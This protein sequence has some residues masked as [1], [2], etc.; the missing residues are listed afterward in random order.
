MDLSY[1][2]AASIVLKCYAAYQMLMKEGPKVLEW[3][4][5]ITRR[6]FYDIDEIITE[7][8][9]GSI[10][11]G[12]QI[13]CSG[14]LTKY[15]QTLLP[16]SYLRHVACNAKEKV[17]SRSIESNHIR[18][19]RRLTF[20]TTSLQIPVHIIPSLQN[21]RMCFLY[22]EN[23]STFIYPINDKSDNPSKKMKL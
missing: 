12:T 22:P 23:F 1:V 4:S 10:P 7:Y 6:K 17:V 13:S 8:R 15:S 14:F 3:G 18:E 21:T 2:D 19:Q 16:M 5:N 11:I 9:N 20:T